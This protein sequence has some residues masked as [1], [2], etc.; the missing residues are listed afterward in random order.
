MT[1][2]FNLEPVLAHRERLEKEQQLVLATALMKLRDAE[3]Y[4]DDLIARRDALRDRLRDHHA[5]ME[6][7]ELRA[8]YAHCDYLD[9]EIVAQYAVVTTVSLAAEAE[10]AKLVAATK[11]KRVIETLKTRR[12]ETFEAAAATVERNALDDI[13]ARTFDRA[14]AH[15]ETQR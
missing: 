5:D 15:R 4:R 7:T 9:R 2:V 10:R 8:A 1:F 11:D 6:L 12:R 3:R 13:N 14:Q